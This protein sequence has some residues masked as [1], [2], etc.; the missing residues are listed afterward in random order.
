MKKIIAVLIAVFFVSASL[1]SEPE[2]SPVQEEQF[3]SKGKK[4]I[5]YLFAPAG[6]NPLPLVIPLLSKGR[7]A[8]RAIERWREIA[9]REKFV[10]ASPQALARSG[11]SGASEGPEFFRGLIESI[12]TKCAIDERRIYL[13][14]HKES[15]TMA[16]ALGMIESEYYAAI[17]S[18]FGSLDTFSY[19]L[20]ERARRKIPV[21]MLIGKDDPFF[22]LETIKA[23]RD[24]LNARNFPVEIILIPG[25]D[26][27]YNRG[28]DVVNRA[29]WDFL[30]AHGLP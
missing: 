15:A 10:V 26:N 14:G 1:A 22:P 20:I 24:A 5:Y 6:D 29:A 17:V 4:R 30:K 27:D 19:H 13:F 9:A 12:K 2:K 23:T 3:L 16:I 25:H 28:F 21:G 8:K 11:W 7:D 18:Y